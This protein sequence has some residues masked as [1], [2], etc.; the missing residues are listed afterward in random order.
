MLFT[1]GA[2]FSNS[3]TKNELLSFESALIK[4]QMS[5]ED[6]FYEIAKST[7]KKSIIF[8][9]R[10]VMD[11]FAYIP[12]DIS[13]ELLS[14]NNWT[15]PQL[16]YG[17][18]DAVIHLVS[19]AIGVKHHYTTL[20]NLARK[21]TPEEAAEL[22]YKIRQVYIGFFYIFIIINFIGHENLHII[23]NRESFEEKINRVKK[24]VKLLI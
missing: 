17:R 12:N 16:R 21:E 6:S 19:A 24:K 22:D 23:E 18:Y 3:M 2:T 13:Q 1:G 20:N 15:L 10:G 8:F 11:A 7:K 9:D 5:L 14:M 4:C